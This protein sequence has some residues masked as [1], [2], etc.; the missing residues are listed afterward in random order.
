[1]ATIKLKRRKEVCVEKSLAS[2]SRPG[3]RKKKEGP[4]ES[5]SVTIAL[6]SMGQ[7][8]GTPDFHFDSVGGVE[9]KKNNED[10]EKIRD[11]KGEKGER[12]GKDGLCPLLPPL[13]GKK[14]GRDKA[15]S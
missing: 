6:S 7:R 3:R 4:V 9:K 2:G 13:E 1:M 10:E 15:S 12:K 11:L 14:R 5:L 8:S